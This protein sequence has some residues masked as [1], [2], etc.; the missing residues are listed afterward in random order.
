M[1][2]TRGM[3]GRVDSSGA[4]TLTRNVDTAA[5]LAWMKG[6]VVFRSTPLGEV[7][8]ELGRWYDVEVR[9]GDATLGT[10]RLTAELRDE[11]LDET[12]RRLRMILGITVERSGRTV[13][14]KPRT[15]TA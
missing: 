9:L 4:A 2:L 11:S 13:V 1:V 14:L 5:Y 7:A 15:P 8:A 6:T 3:L 12:L 10:R